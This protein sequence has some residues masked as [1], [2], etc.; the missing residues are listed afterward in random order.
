MVMIIITGVILSMGSTNKGW[1]YT[2]TLSLIGWAHTQN[3][4]CY[5]EVLHILKHGCV[6][7]NWVRTAHIFV[8]KLGLFDTKP[9]LIARFM[10]PT[11]GPS[12]ANRTQVGPML[13]PW[14]LLSGII[15]TNAGLL[16]IGSLGTHQWNFNQNTTNWKSNWP[17]RLDRK[18]KDYVYGNC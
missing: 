7:F 14:T 13:A 18:Y 4:P 8:I 10:G 9:S 16:T 1:R 2:V 17:V 3:D 5:N 15:W 11:W 12:W 6:V